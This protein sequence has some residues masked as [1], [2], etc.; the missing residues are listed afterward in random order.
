[1]RENSLKENSWHYAAFFFTLL[2]IVE[3]VPVSM[4]IYN[5]SYIMSNKTALAPKQVNTSVRSK[6][7]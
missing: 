6:L 2:T 1:M 5:L 4:F 3:V 7:L